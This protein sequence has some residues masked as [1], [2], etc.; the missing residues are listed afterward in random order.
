M[1]EDWFGEDWPIY[2]FSFITVLIIV[3]MLWAAIYDYKHCL[4]HEQHGYIYITHRVGNISY[5]QPYPNNV[6]VQWDNE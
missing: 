4:K 6:C 5:A 2:L 1:I 3:L